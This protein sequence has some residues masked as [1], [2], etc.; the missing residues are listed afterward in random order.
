MTSVGCGVIVGVSDGL[1]LL[2]GAGDI[3][4]ECTRLM[5]HRMD[6]YHFYHNNNE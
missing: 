2:D 6:L 1:R 4:S 5:I 3:V